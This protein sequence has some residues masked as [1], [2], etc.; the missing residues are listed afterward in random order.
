[1]TWQEE[2]RLLDEQLASGKV[3]ADEYRKRRDD[4]LAG[5]ISAPVAD[6][7]ESAVK[8]PAEEPATPYNGFEM[9]LAGHAAGFHADTDDGQD[10]MGI[11][12]DV[13]MLAD[14]VASRLIAPPLSIGLFGNWGTGKSFFMR[15]MQSRIRATAKAAERAERA[16]GRR[17]PEISTFCS[18]VRQ[19]T[20]NAWHYAEANLWASLATQ[21]FDNIAA[22]GSEDDLSRR[23][24]EL[25][26]LR[27]TEPSL[28]TQLSTV[29]LERMLVAARHERAPVRLGLTADDFAWIARETGVETA[30]TDQIREFAGEAADATTEFRRGWQLLRGNVRAW[31]TL[32]VGLAFAVVL[33]V[34][35]RGPLWP[36]V[37]SAVSVLAAATPTIATVR[38]AVRRIRDAADRAD[39]ATD[40]R[41][42]EL[43]AEADRLERAV[44]DL[45]PGRDATAFAKSR[46]ASDDYRQ[47]LGI[48]SLL[49]RDL[50]TFA[51]IL[52]R[53]DGGGLERVVLYIDDLDRCP[54]DVVVKVLEAIH[55]L[56]ALPVFVVVVG[57]DPRWLRKAIATHYADL[58]TDLAPEQYLEKIFQVPFQLSAMNEDAYRGLIRSMAPTRPRSPTTQN[59]LDAP[60]AELPPTARPDTSEVDVRPQQLDLSSAEVDFL[61]GVGKLVPT[62]RTAKRLLNLYR[63]IRSRLTNVELS[64]FVDG[65]AEPAKAVIVLL[66]LHAADAHTAAE[67]FASVEHLEL[68][69]WDEAVAHDWPDPKIAEIAAAV[70]GIDELPQQMSRYLDW[71]PLA[72]RFSFDD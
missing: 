16:A 25:A 53:E 45:A 43:D 14:L 15:S 38:K 46:Y 68:K 4:I 9:P 3:T 42:A 51:A 71:L 59:T 41:L 60:V 1:M 39:Q 7:S 24:D 13:D 36:A 34:V 66:A 10:R 62:P 67:L 65:D 72:R 18:S 2:L 31:A 19:I 48:V 26:E 6:A 11:V 56:V 29:R 69:S 58:L 63:L 52:A 22:N 23:A 54:S 37:V 30:T 57:V 50:E 27:R 20:F 17:G 35:V 47:H 33:A 49:R 55:L 12:A 21:I 61:C 28:L 64:E 44:G 40:Q 8:A 70:R 5:A 32:T